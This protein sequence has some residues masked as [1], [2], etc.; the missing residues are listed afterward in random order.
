M[1]RVY[2]DHFVDKMIILILIFPR[3]TLR[4]FKHETVLVDSIS[5]L[6]G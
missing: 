3:Y 1:M 6:Y 4:L 2:I 5:V